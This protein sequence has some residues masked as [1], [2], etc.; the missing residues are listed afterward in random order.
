VER[1]ECCPVIRFQI[2]SQ[3]AT[4]DANL[5]RTFGFVNDRQNRIDRIG[6]NFSSRAAFICVRFLVRPKTLERGST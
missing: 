5:L 6:C 2:H 4:A 3:T 1:L